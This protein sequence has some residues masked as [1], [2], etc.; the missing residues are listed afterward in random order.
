[1]IAQ[2][3][4]IFSTG[5]FKKDHSTNAVL[6]TQESFIAE[7]EQSLQENKEL[8]QHRIRE[9]NALK[10]E[11]HWL[12]TFFPHHNDC[13]FKIDH[14]EENRIL[15]ITTEHNKK[16]LKLLV[17]VPREQIEIAAVYMRPSEDIL[18]IDDIKLN[19]PQCDIRIGKIIFENLVFYSRLLGLSLIVGQFGE[20]P[21]TSFNELVQFYRLIGFEV[22]TNPEEETG[23]IIYRLNGY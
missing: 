14:D 4:N 13:N 22:T 5:I 15:F 17:H 7:L 9:V 1:M 12:Y 2:F 19:F 11:L 10:K 6:A 16:D 20:L 23:V 3:R 21:N 18:A 8:L